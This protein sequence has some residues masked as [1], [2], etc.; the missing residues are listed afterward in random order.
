M[1]PPP[2]RFRIA[3]SNQELGGSL[4]VTPL[5][6]ADS[7][8]RVEIVQIL[9]DRQDANVNSHDILDRTT[10]YYAAIMGHGEKVVKVLL[11]DGRI[12]FNFRDDE[13]K[14]PLLFA[15]YRGHQ[16]VV[17]ILLED[18][19]VETQCRGGIRANGASYGGLST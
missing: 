19:R 18:E 5:S 11:G 7:N 16:T 10:L 8:G 2:A 12:D 13:Y 1:R 4:T 14:T 9:V 6:W 3:A 15:V 17:R